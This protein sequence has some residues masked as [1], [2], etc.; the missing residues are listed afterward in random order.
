MTDECQINQ[1]LRPNLSLCRAIRDAQKEGKMIETIKAD[2]TTQAVDAILNAAGPGLR[3]GGGVDGAVHRVAG[4]ALRRASM[5][6]APCPPGEAR[7]TKGGR[8]PARF[9]IHAVGPRWR[10][11]NAE[12][13]LARCYGA[14]FALAEANG[15][16]TL[17]SPFISCGVFGFP[18]EVGRSIAFAAA[19]AHL[20]TS[21]HIERIT[22]VT[23]LDLPR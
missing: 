15:C 13:L 8:L 5:K 3:G 10:D 22:F 16:Q 9:V 2:I 19:E 1:E 14:A 6:L 18:I 17:A 20:A 12:D 4:P 11:A 23:L 21:I 7:I